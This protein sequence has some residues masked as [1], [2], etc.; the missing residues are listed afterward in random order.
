MLDDVGILER[1]VALFCVSTE[2]CAG[3]HALGQA[4]R[5]MSGKS[6]TQDATLQN[7][8]RATGPRIQR[9]ASAERGRCLQR[10]EGL[11][12]ATTERG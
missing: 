2:I 9:S 11:T 3:A 8:I 12:A 7:V 5:R 1:M 4:M 6:C 10:F